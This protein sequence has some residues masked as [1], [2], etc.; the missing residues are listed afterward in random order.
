MNPGLGIPHST[1]GRAFCG[2]QGKR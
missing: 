1:C 2:A